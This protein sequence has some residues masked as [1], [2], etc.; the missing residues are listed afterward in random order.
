MRL[1]AVSVRAIPLWAALAA[2][3]AV[4]VP[5]QELLTNSDLAPRPD[6]TQPADWAYGDFGTGG[7]P[8]YDPEGGREGDGA[9][10]VRCAS[11]QQRGAW[12]QN[13]ALG[14]ARFVIASGRYRTE[15]AGAKP[16]LRLTWLRGLEGWQFIADIRLDLPT[17]EQWREFESLFRAPQEAAAVAPELFNFFGAGTVWWDEL[18]L[19]PATREEI[20]AMAGAEL[21]RAPRPDEVDY[22]PAEGAI[23]P[24][25][26]PAFVWLPV[27]GVERWVVQ[28]APRGE[29]EGPDAVS[30]QDWPL[31]VL[32]PHETLRP[33]QWAWRYGF[34]TEVG[35]I[36]S[37]ARR[38]TIPEDAVE[39]PLPR[40]DEVMARIPDVHP[41]AYFHRDQLEE[42]RAKVAQ[43]PAYAEM[44]GPIIRAA[45]SR[46]G[47]ELYPEPDYL[48]EGGLERTRAYAESFRTMRPFTAGM[49]TCAA[50]YVLT[51]DERFGQEARRRLMHFMTWDPEGP[52]SVS[53]N[54][55]AAMDLIMRAPR[56]YDWIWDLLSPDERATCV[57]VLARRVQQAHELHRA[58]PFTSRPYSSHPGRM[59]GFVI[60]DCIILAHEVPEARAWLD[61]TLRLLWS[62]Y[63]A[64][65]NPD[66][67]WAEGPGYWNAYIGMLQPVVLLLDN[68]G[69][70][71]K[72]KP[73][74]RN[75]GWFGLYAVPVGGKM[76]PFGDGHEG[77]VG[78]GN[79]EI[80]YRWST[81]YRN[82]YW[83]W[84]AEQL[85][86]GPGS[87]VGQFG[88]YDPT[89]QPRPPSDLPQARVF[90]DIGLAALH[91]N[92]A[93]PPNNVY[94][95]MRSSP[96]GSVSHSHASHNAI[97]IGA[98]GE[99]LAIS[100]GYYQLYG[101]PHHAQWTRQTRAHNSILV[102]GEGQIERSSTANGRIT[103]FDDQDEYC[104]TVGDA[105][106]AYG[107][108][109]D[110]FLRRVLFIRP[111]TF[112]ICDELNAAKASRFQWLLHARE[113]MALDAEAQT[114]L[115]SA[116]EARL[117]TRIVAP[118]GLQMSQE[119]GFPVAPERESPDQFHFTA[120]TT[121]RAEAATFLT[122]LTAYR[123]GEESRVPA[124]EA[125]AGEGGSGLLL[126]WEDESALVV[127][128]LHEAMMARVD[129]VETEAEVAVIRRDAAGAI[130]SVY[131]YGGSALT[132][133][134]RP[135]G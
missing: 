69:V 43:D 66:G 106:A 132:V 105:T 120:Q 92:L 111:D 9:A 3:F 28:Y 31:T 78:R 114:V 97:A 116:G 50:A 18:H 123:A 100:S 52:T 1:P 90:P 38:F 74:C 60:E 37:A 26:P 86:A 101:S 57:R 72:N 19:R 22:S 91:S 54:D 16:M 131:S 112:V 108:R 47:E 4:P 48:P 5:A 115:I 96:Y 121:E 113:E 129:E 56:T 11:D 39:F 64:W 10:G 107:G 88:F 73:F 126:R 29:F 36:F 25:N 95:L 62:V 94:L 68:I 134:G 89:L 33:G 76:T 119:R 53:N 99:A 65:G 104:Y 75:N 80:L 20:A 45:Q 35:P 87:A 117:L 77:S 55:E 103:A 98:F 2:L 15:G 21:D 79:G 44:A 58:M 12:R 133:A 70:P 34:V 46:L 82:P 32:T 128:R 118:T 42:L 23:S 102:D 27:T 85:G 7:E 8:L 109:L 93:D 59:I 51:G 130:T 127:W 81:L 135:V 122:V 41:R 71:F 61:Y 24:T 110:L 83:R 49:E 125:I 30:V 40:I 17:S 14:D 63:P 84:Y 6:G 124:V 67:G 13:A